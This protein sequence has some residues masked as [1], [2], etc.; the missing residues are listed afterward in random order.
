MPVAPAGPRRVRPC[1]SL[2]RIPADRDGAFPAARRSAADA[3][4]FDL[5]APE[6]PEDR[7]DQARRLAIDGMADLD[8]TGKSLAMRTHGFGSHGF[9][10]DIAELLRRGADRIDRLIVPGVETVDQLR[11]LTRILHTA[12]PAALELQLDTPLGF[13]NAGPLAAAL[14]TGRALHG[15]HPPYPLA[16]PWP[17]DRAEDRDDAVG[18]RGLRGWREAWRCVLSQSARCPAAQGVRLIDSQPDDAT[19]ADGFAAAA[20]A[21]AALGYQGKWIDDPVRASLCNRAF[22]PTREAV[23]AARAVLAACVAADRD[24]LPAVVLDGRMVDAAAIGRAGDIVALDDTLR[25]APPEEPAAQ[26]IAQ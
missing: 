3:V 26:R 7:R 13:A 5:A 24:G 1:R 19:D 4:V 14:G 25:A 8:W 2:L 20:T 17:E 12:A 9:H 22:T 21:L 18:R 16:P 11:T 23:D 6:T 15:L 10:A